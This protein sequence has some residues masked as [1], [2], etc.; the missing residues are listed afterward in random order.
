[1]PC[2]FSRFVQY[3]DAPFIF[4]ICNKFLPKRRII[5]PVG[6]TTKKYTI[7]I[8]IGETIEPN[9]IPNL[10]HNLFSGV[11]NLEL[12]IPKI[13]KIIDKTNDHSLI[14]SPDFKGHKATIKNITKNTNPK[15]L[16]DEIFILELEVIVNYIFKKLYIVN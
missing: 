9:K 10:N 1:M 16:F 4:F 12:K 13:K 8:I 6:V 11:N 2:C 3:V 15:L 5:I 7:P 14:S